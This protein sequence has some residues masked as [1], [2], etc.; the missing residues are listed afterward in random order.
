[1]LALFPNIIACIFAVAISYSTPTVGLG[2]RSIAHISLTLLWF[3]SFLITITVSKL[4]LA[5]GK[6]HLYIVFTKDAIIGLG[7][8]MTVAIVYA[9]V[10]NSC[11]CWSNGLNGIV[12]RSLHVLVGVDKTLQAN[13]EAIYPGLV[14]GGLAAQ[15]IVFFLMWCLFRSREGNESRSYG[16]GT[17]GKGTYR[18]L[19]H[20]R[21]GSESGM[22]LMN[23]SHEDRIK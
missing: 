15:S 17:P 3:L 8:V 22:P 19:V 7:T 5:T 16:L 14:G 13:A 6:Y 4:G 12:G 11:W 18:P 9:G 10:F 20:L 2:C 1:L 23:I 21:I